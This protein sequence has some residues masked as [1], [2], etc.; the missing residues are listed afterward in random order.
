MTNFQFAEAGEPSQ[1]IETLDQLRRYLGV[2]MQLEHATIPPYLTALYSIKPG[3][4][5]DA[6]HILRVVAVEEMLHL[7][8]AANLMNAVEGDPDLTIPGFVPHYPCYLPNGEHD[9]KVGI[10]GFNKQTIDTFKQIERPEPGKGLRHRHKHPAG[11]TLLGALP[12]A[13]LHYDTI[14]EFYEAIKRG[15][16]RLEEREQA[17]GSTIFKGD[18]KRQITSEYYYSGGGKLFPV[19]DLESALAAIRLIIEQGEGIGRSDG[20]AESIC[21]SEKELSHYYRF[22]QLTHGRYYQPGDKKH[23]PTGPEFKVDWEEAYPVQPNV[24]LAD[25]PAGSELHDMAL[26]FNGAYAKFLETLT[27]AYK[28]EPQLLMSA[29]PQMFEFRELMTQ[30]V[31]NPLPGGSGFHAAPTFEVNP[32]TTTLAELAASAPTGQV[33][34]ASTV[35]ALAAAAGV[36]T[37]PSRLERFLALSSELTAFAVFDLQG[38]GQAEAYFKTVEDIVGAAVVDELLAAYREAEPVH[39]DQ[40]REAYLRR[41]LF[42]NEKLGPIARNIIKMWFSGTWYELP[43]TWTAAYGPASRSGTF[44]VAPSSYVEGLLWTTIGAHPAG[45]KPQGYGSWAEAPRIPPVSGTPARRP[46]PVIDDQ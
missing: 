1:E 26:A 46:R 14:G 11:T 31:R 43:A 3:T 18:H 19:V 44:V 41:H 15:F 22:D 32:I 21:D 29:V 6:V 37:A 25:M 10:G 5:R 12:E 30:L 28:G 23:A 36:N 17:K 40:A 4:N 42:G 39:G 9:F 13:Q 7:T 16:K 27:R 34:Q 35:E 20:H 2:A 33:D 38:T 24:K 45:A 8:L